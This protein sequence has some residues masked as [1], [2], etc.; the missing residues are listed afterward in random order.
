MDSSKNS[1]VTSD[2]GDAVLAGTLSV[3][4]VASLAR[5]PDWVTAAFLAGVSVRDFLGL[6]TII[7][8]LAIVTVSARRVVAAIQTNSPGSAT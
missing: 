4:L 3:G 5:C 7:A 1:P 8:F 2:A 6:I